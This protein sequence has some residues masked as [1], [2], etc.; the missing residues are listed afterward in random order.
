MNCRSSTTHFLGTSNQL[1]LITYR[2]GAVSH[3]TIQLTTIGSTEAVGGQYLGLKYQHSAVY[4]TDGIRLVNERAQRQL[5]GV[6]QQL[7]LNKSR[8]FKCKRNGTI[9]LKLAAVDIAEDGWQTQE[10]SNL[11]LIL[12]LTVTTKSIFTRL[13]SPTIA[14]RSHIITHRPF[15]SLNFLFR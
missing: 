10:S 15:R 2:T 9:L 11:G 7:K 1:L 14:F 6:R 5:L 4:S 12:P 8:A 3:F 13:N